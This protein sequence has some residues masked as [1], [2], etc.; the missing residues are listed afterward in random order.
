M[1]GNS[2]TGNL[3]SVVPLCI[4]IVQR[5]LHIFSND[6]HLDEGD[7]KPDADRIDEDRNL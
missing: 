7:V 2:I 6:A 5:I 3:L 1:G 4:M